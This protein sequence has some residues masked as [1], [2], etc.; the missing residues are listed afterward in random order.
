MIKVTLAQEADHA[1]LLV[2]AK[3]SR[4]TKDFSNQVMFSS[5]AAYEKGWILRADQEGTAWTKPLGFAC[6]RHKTRVPQTVLYFIG[7]AKEAK[8]LG[9]GR[10]LLEEIL[11]TS[12]HEELVLNVM[13]ENNEARAFYQRLGF[14]PTGARVLDGQGI[15]LR[16]IGR[17]LA[18]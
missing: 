12:P 14:E 3:Q 18:R 10:A 13:R 15:Q 6:V 16:L 11:R 5:P 9:V 17:R 7:V 8:R 1:P 2:I 4:Y